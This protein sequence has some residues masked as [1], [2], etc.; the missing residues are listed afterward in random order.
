MDGIT[1]IIQEL[2]S[3]VHEEEWFEFKTNR[4]DADEVGEY[5]S[6]LSNAAAFVGVPQAYMVW[7]IEDGTHELVGT[8]VDYNKDVSGEPLKHYLSRQI[9]PDIN[10]SFGET[11]LDGKRIVLLSIPAAKTVPI[12]YKHVRYIRIG[13]SKERLERFPEKESYLFSVLRNGIPTIE[14]IASEHQDLSFT[15]L[16]SYYGARGIRLNEDTFAKNLGLLAPDGSYN[17]LAQLLSDN[18]HIPIR[19]AIFMGK[20]KAD[21]L[22]SIREFGF[23]CLL[24]SLDEVLRYGDVL[25]IIQ[26]DERDRVVERNEESLFDNIL[27]QLATQLQN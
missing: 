1:S 16:L 11:L 3:H 17:L 8:D 20:T 2:R 13:S 7:G 22:F 5:I 23:Q 6:A 9:S 14:T 27:P 18:S 12:A 4:F 15:Q 26:T 24:Y 19:V 21:K 10:F 25:N